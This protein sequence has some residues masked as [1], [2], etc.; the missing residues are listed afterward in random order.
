MLQLLQILTVQNEDDLARQ[1]LDI[2]ADA[3]GRVFAVIAM[4][5][6]KEKRGETDAAAGLLDE[7]AALT[8]DVQQFASRSSALN[9]IAIR[10][11]GHGQTGRSRELAIE[12]LDAIAEIRDE[13]SQSDALAM[14]AVV[15][16]SIGLEI[17]D[18]EIAAI[19]EILRL[20]SN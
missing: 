10:F 18:E 8:E 6:V 20:T 12:S 3:A 1:T 5:D 4:A 16:D 15:Y 19:K 13:S 17:A 9:E 2:I 7:A 11:A 14:L